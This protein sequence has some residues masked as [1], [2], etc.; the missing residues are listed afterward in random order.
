MSTEKKVLAGLAAIAMVCMTTLVAL[1][2]MTASEAAKIVR[3]LAL[4][5]SG[6]VGGF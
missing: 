5:V 1:D 3:D 6:L 4:P 2:K